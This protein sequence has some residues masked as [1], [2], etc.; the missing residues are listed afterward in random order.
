[1]TRRTKFIIVAVVCLLS[2]IFLLSDLQHENRNLDEIAIAQSSPS[3][4]DVTLVSSSSGSTTPRFIALSPGSSQEELESRFDQYINILDEIGFRVSEAQFEEAS[5]ELESLELRLNQLSSD[6]KF[7]FVTYMVNYLQNNPIN[8]ESLVAFS[9]AWNNL[10]LDP[11]IELAA[12]ELL[13]PQFLEEFEFELAI[14]QFERILDRNGL[15]SESQA[16]G[17]AEAQFAMQNYQS[18]IALLEESLSD[19]S[20]QVNNRKVYSLL[21]ESYFRTGEYNRAERI[22]LQVLEISDDLQDWIDMA[23]FYEATNESQKLD[24]LLKEAE[25]L[26]YLDRDGNWVR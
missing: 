21:F 8:P 22:G 15:L 2:I 25:R 23:S 18:A 1:M 14:I 5:N 17:M 16:V 24:N 13:G 11:E 4:N 10:S 26:G 19:D 6:D 12:A 3:G 7:L 20:L 9:T